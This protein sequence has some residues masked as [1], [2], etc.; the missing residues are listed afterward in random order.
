M[1]GWQDHLHFEFL[2]EHVLFPGLHL[3]SGWHF[4]AASLLTVALCFLER[5][6]TYAISKNWTPFA[7]TRRSRTR[8]ALWKAALHWLAAIDRLLYMLI[9]M[10]F[11]VGLILVTAT[12]LAVGTFVIEYLDGQDYDYRRQDTEHV[13]EPLLTSSPS[14]DRPHAMHAYP[15]YQPPSV[16]SYG[17]SHT[18]SSSSIELS[19]QSDT[20]SPRTTPYSEAHSA[21]TS[22]PR[23]RSKPTAIFIHPNES[24]LARADA[25]AQQMGLTGETERVK[26]IMH[27]LEGEPAWK[28]G[29]GK[30]IAR[31]LMNRTS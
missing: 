15:T 13:K 18:P 1:D 14:Y 7:W 17:H 30:D 26:G 9:A 28:I 31:Q 25:A 4:L 21:P 11:S 8:R 29:E 20:M 24:N 10:T 5:A 23:S 2:G 3:D 22:R 6:L 19:M 16:R 27:P 12:S